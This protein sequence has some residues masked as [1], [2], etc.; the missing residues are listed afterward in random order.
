MRDDAVDECLHHGVFWTFCS[1]TAISWFVQSL[2]VSVHLFCVPL[3][4]PLLCASVPSSS[5]CHL[6]CVP[7][8]LPLLCASVPSSSV[9]LC[10]FLFCVPPLLCVSVPSSSVCH[11]FCVPLC[12]PLLCASVPSSSVCLCAFLFCVP[13]FLALQGAMQRGV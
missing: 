3:C 8:C 1:S 11:L 9:C 6:F 10:A 5:V 7:L 13:L 12:L 4:L 2:V